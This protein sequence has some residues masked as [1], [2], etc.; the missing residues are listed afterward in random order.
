MPREI[1]TFQSKYKTYQVYLRFDKYRS[2]GRTCI[3]L[4]EARTHEPVLVATVNIDDYHL[5]QPNEVIIKNYSENEGVLD[6][7]IENGIIGK[8]KAWISTGWVTVP[9]CDLLKTH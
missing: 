3:E 9:V 8:P 2:N 6:F 4:L 5:L 1:Y 7:M